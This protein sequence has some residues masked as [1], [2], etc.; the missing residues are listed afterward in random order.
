M[1][2]PL[3][4]GLL[5]MLEPEIVFKVKPVNSTN[6]QRLSQC[7]K[8]GISKFWMLWKVEYVTI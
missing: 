2:S 1:S 7:L 6:C 8:D 3:D 5:I 4:I